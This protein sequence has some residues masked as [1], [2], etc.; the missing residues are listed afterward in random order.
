VSDRQPGDG[1]TDDE[2]VATDSLLDEWADRA[3]MARADD[4]GGRVWR[5]LETAYTLSRGP[6]GYDVS[7]MDRGRSTPRARF[8]SKLE[9]ERF[10][11]LLLALPWRS[12]RGMARPFPKGLAAGADC[13]SGDDGV[14]L[15]TGGR[16][17]WFRSEIDARRYSH[18]SNLDLDSLSELLSS[19]SGAVD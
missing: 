2:N 11:L 19:P 7:A 4:G 14:T 1:T 15:R 12:E 3:G 10:V 17:A 5:D 18:A 8:G 6:D 13:Q 16:A 9:A